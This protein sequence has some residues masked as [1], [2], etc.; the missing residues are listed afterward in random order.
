M[1]IYTIVVLSFERLHAICSP[2]THIPI[3][4]PYLITIVFSSITITIP[5]FFH[6]QLVYD[7]VGNV[8]VTVN[9]MYENE[10][11]NT[12][13][14]STVLVIGN[15]LKMFCDLINMKCNMLTVFLK[16][17]LGTVLP[18]VIL[19][20]NKIKICLCLR[21]TNQILMEKTWKV[22]CAT[23]LVFFVC[24]SFRYVITIFEFIYPLRE[25][26]GRFCAAKGRYV[27][28]CNMSLLGVSYSLSC[29]DLFY[30]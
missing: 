18:M 27:L 25:D 7:K 22:L 14:H 3:F 6:Y 30:K 16:T 28:Y 29:Y 4:W 11:Y 24:H 1:T 19:I 17:P 21:E 26:H 20:R 5:L 15:K 12:Y 23:V 2:L 8:F 10:V 9:P 13:F